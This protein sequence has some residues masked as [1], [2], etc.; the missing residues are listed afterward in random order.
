MAIGDR[1]LGRLDRGDDEG[2]GLADLLDDD[3]PQSLERDLDGVARQVDALVHAGGDA[4]PADELL[5]V[6]RLVVVAA[7]DDEG[8]DETGLLVGA[9]QRE[10]LRGAHLHGDGAERVDD[11]RPERHERQR[12]RQLRLE[13]VVFALWL[14]HGRQREAA[15]E[16]CRCLVVNH[17]VVYV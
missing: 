7:G 1:L 15:T 6:D 3:A 16:R 17:N 8:D 14:G 4:D 12:R 5:G 10:V 2:L 13:D 11:R 9:E